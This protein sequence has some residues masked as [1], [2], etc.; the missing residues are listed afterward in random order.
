MNTL[1]H[2]IKE[3]FRGLFAARMM[4]AVSICSIAL[5]LFFLGGA[6]IAYVNIRAWVSTISSQI[7]ILAFVTDVV[8]DDT[9]VAEEL[10]TA[11][12]NREEV[13][14]VT[15]VTK[16]QA[17]SRFE[18][19]YGR[20]MLDAVEKN[21]LPASL[22][23]TL[24]EKFKFRSQAAD[25]TAYLQQ[26]H[27]VESVMYSK[28]WIGVIERVRGYFWWGTIGI[29]IVVFFA[30]FFLI[31]NTVK[32]T[33]YA[34]RE[35]VYNMQMV[36]ATSGYIKAPFI[37]EGILQGFAGGCLAIAGL[38]CVKFGLQHFSLVGGAWKVTAIVL[39]VLGV[40]FGWIGSHSAVRKFLTI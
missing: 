39:P 16:A 37:I 38:A 24:L 14:A 29:G 25:L 21:P 35:L 7:D 10:L 28:E 36:G 32:L 6:A 30:L 40:V 9:R 8:A 26:L 31:S 19:W 17:W 20:T 4:T 18:Q 5:A 27:G 34:R 11:V 15:L 23:I 13:A 33:I 1:I 12:G 2:H 22:E 3:A